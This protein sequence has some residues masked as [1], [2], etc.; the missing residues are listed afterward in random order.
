MLLLLARS[1]W[2]A[3]KTLLYSPCLYVCLS[4]WRTSIRTLMKFD[5]EQCLLNSIGGFQFWLKSNT[6]DG[7]LTWTKVYSCVTTHISSATPYIFIGTR[8][9]SKQISTK[10]EIRIFYSGFFFFFCVWRDCDIN[11]KECK[12][13]NPSAMRSFPNFCIRQS[14]TDLSFLR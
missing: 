1:Y 7:H 13:Q 8:N 5:V 2:K 14:V 4:V 11:R 12:R 6:S 9:V 3:V 10:S